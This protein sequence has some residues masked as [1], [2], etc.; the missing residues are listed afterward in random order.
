VLDADEA[1]VEW[2]FPVTKVLWYPAAASVHKTERFKT[3]TRKAG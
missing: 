3:Y 2:N 1:A